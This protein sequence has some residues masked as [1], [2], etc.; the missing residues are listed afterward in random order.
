MHARV[1]RVVDDVLRDRCG[2][3]AAQGLDG[4]WRAQIEPSG[5]YALAIV[6]PTV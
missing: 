6:L 2:N 4:E 1:L 5:R 3:A